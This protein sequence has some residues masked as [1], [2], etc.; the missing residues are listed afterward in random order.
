[1]ISSKVHI[2]LLLRNKI[3]KIISFQSGKRYKKI[4]P[5]TRQLNQSEKFLEHIGPKFFGRLS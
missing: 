3:E 5:L 4:N 2:L 1:M